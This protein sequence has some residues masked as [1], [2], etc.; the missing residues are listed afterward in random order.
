MTILPMPFWAALLCVAISLWSSRVY[1]EDSFTVRNGE[2]WV[3]II[4]KP[5]PAA[6]AWLGL[7]LAEMKYQGKEYKACW[8]VVGKFVVILDDS[9]DKTPVP[10]EAFK[11]DV[12]T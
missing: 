3:R 6:P 4:D 8:I 9:G 10:A 11:K 1:A 12:R 5:C 7:R 2:D